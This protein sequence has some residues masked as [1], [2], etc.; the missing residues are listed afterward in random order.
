MIG[1]ILTPKRAVKLAKAI[2]L[3]RL[4]VI[5]LQ[6]N[7][8]PFVVLPCLTI[9]EKC[10][11]TPRLDPSFQNK[12]EQEGG[13]VILA[14]SLAPLWD[15][16]VQKQ[17]FKVLGPEDSLACPG[18]I[19]IIMAALEFLLQPQDSVAEMTASVS[20]LALTASAEGGD[21]DGDD[22]YDGRLESLLTKMTVTYRSSAGFRKGLNTRRLES[23]LPSIVD[24]ATVSASAE[25]SG[26]ERQ[27]RAITGFLEALIELSKAPPTAINQMQLC[28]EQL[29]AASNGDMSASISSI[30]SSTSPN[31]S[32]TSS[33]LSRS[34]S[35]LHRI[36]SPRRSSLRREKPV[37]VLKRV[38]TGESVLEEEKDKNAAWRQII[39][40]TDV[41]RHSAM[42]LD[43]K[44]HWHRVAQIEWPRY[45]A[46]LRTEN[47]IWADEQGLVK[48]RLDGSEG[49]LRMRGRL[50]RIQNTHRV[51]NKRRAKVRDAIPEPDELSSAISR[52]NDAPWDDPFALVQGEAP[53]EE[54]KL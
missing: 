23:L 29:K 25:G 17:V 37:P 22:D 54:G 45:V 5:F 35:I 6:S 33:P 26:A 20:S 32:A 10:L 31:A 47:G 46:S 34:S 3:P 8:A 28:V 53:I 15:D 13:F 39:L 44:E 27:R 11:A 19:A 14:R 4:L 1:E 40:A 50:E 41:Q 12:F 9:V 16:V 18:A 38:L 24:F 48:W 36:G 43:R 2:S 42:T 7:Q 51:D 52:I 21:A 30:K 49:P